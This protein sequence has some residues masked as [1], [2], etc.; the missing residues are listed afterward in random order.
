MNYMSNKDFKKTNAAYHLYC[1]ILLSNDNWCMWE[2]NENMFECI[3]TIV[4]MP[5][6]VISHD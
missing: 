2:K 4:S 3:Y 5:W 1:N 6:I